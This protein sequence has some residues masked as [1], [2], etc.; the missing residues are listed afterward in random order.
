MTKNKKLSRAIIKISGVDATKF[1]QGLFSCNIED[2]GLNEGNYSL[3]LSNKGRYNFDLFVIKLTDYYLIDIAKEY[4]QEF[5]KKLNFYK[6]VS[7]VQIEVLDNYN[8]YASSVFRKED[9]CYKDPRHINLG[10]RLISTK[11]V[12]DDKIMNEEDYNNLRYNLGIL[13]SSEIREGI[14]P[15]EYGFDELQAISYTKGCYLG[16]EF[17]NATK[18]K[19]E[20][21][22]R[23]LFLKGNF[24]TIKINDDVLNLQSEVVGK[25]VYM[26]EGFIFANLKMQYIDEEVYISGEK[27]KFIK[28]DW[29]TTYSLN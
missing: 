4:A 20:V 16:Q 10:Y 17:T 2:I 25:V 13:E 22:K 12:D 5:V 29:I 21:R 28:R 11:D 1:L 14:I 23:V 15:L 18:N 8:V 3:M 26:S 19:L 9:I 27:I 6:L 7:K 24:N